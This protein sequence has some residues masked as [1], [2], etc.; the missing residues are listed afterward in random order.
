[1][2]MSRGVDSLGKQKQTQGGARDE[3]EDEEEKDEEERV[4]DRANERQEDY[5][6]V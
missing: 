4:S 5:V 1:M 6:S 3:E 2:Q